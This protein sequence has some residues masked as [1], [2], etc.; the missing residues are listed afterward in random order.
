[1]FGW[2]AVFEPLGYDM[3]CVSPL[4]LIGFLIYSCRY[5]EMPSEEKNKISH[6][7]RALEKLRAYL[8]S[9]PSES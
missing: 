2:D 6:R 5:A 3:T 7:G 8:H 4:I 9:L 1:M